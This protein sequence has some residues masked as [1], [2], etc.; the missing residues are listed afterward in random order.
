MVAACAAAVLEKREDS[1]LTLLF[2]KRKK[3]SQFCFT[4]GELR[5]HEEIFAYYACMCT[6]YLLALHTCQHF[7]VRERDTFLLPKLAIDSFG[8]HWSSFQNLSYKKKNQT[9]FHMQ[10]TFY[11][12]M[13]THI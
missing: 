13:H 12:L 8:T 2:S 6:A 10:N 4:Y 7:E 5:K 11:V 9:N 3:I 1:G